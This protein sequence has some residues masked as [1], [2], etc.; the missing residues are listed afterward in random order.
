MSI[1]SNKCQCYYVIIIPTSTTL[2]SHVQIKN[3]FYRM[4]ILLAS[5]SDKLINAF[6]SFPGNCDG[7][8]DGVISHSGHNFLYTD[9][10]C[11]DFREMFYLL[12]YFDNISQ[13]SATLHVVSFSPFQEF[14]ALSI[15]QSNGD[16]GSHSD[17]EAC[18]VMCQG[19]DRR[20]A[21]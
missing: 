8:L 14:K 3:N 4:F 20:V 10:L 16:Y 12:L 19:M 15:A 2:I 21:R 18:D 5:I 13:L 1:Y 6:Y 17:V 9:F 7:Q 11:T